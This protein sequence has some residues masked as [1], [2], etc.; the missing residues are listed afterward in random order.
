MKTHLSQNRKQNRFL[1]TWKS[2]LQTTTNLSFN[3]NPPR[4]FFS[5]FAAE[6]WKQLHQ[7]P[8]PRDQDLTRPRSGGERIPRTTLPQL[9]QPLRDPVPSNIPPQTQGTNTT[10]GKQKKAGAWTWTP[11]RWAIGMVLTDQILRK[12]GP[13]CLAPEPLLATKTDRWVQYH[14]E[15]TNWVKMPA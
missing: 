5:Y 2:I 14:Q 11:W 6:K 3:Q 8:G 10:P 12:Q 9:W 13:P 15:T 1:H 7:G 4:S